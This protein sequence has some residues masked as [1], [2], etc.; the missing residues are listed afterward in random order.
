M[1]GTDTQ[2]VSYRMQKRLIF[3]SKRAATRLGMKQPAYIAMLIEKATQGEP[4][5]TEKELE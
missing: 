4:E 3:K 2:P 5:P 1:N